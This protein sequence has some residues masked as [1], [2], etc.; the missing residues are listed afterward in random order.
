MTYERPWREIQEVEDKN[1]IQE[2]GRAIKDMVEANNGTYSEELLVGTDGFIDAD[3]RLGDTH[4][5][6]LPRLFLDRV[7]KTKQTD[8]H[9]PSIE[10]FYRIASEMQQLSPEL[11]FEIAEAA[12][13]RS[14]RYT[15]R[16]RGKHS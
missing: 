10:E 2:V 14:I 11:S 15:V 5:P 16:S 6:F 8:L 13:R 1:F 7:E 4:P 9:G 3:R 12:D